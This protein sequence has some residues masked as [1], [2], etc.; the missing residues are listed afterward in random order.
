[1]SIY[2]DDDYLGNFPL[3]NRE[4][5]EKVCEL[6]TDPDRQ[7]GP[8]YETDEDATDI[9]GNPISGYVAV[10]I[11]MWMDGDKRRWWD[12]YNELKGKV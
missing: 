2:L 4:I 6:L 12:K 7:D 8:I 5:V 9:D 3:E 11:Y 10:R 1:M